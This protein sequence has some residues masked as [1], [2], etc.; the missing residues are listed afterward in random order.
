M[1]ETPERR[2]VAPF[3]LT[4]MPSS[5]ELA[6]SHRDLH[7]AALHIVFPPKLPQAADEADRE[8]EVDS[9]IC[10]LAAA[11]ARRYSD[12]LSSEGLPGAEFWIR[13]AMMIET[14]GGLVRLP[15]NALELKKTLHDMKPRGASAS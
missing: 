6:G 2:P 5:T 3:S 14:L 12:R 4:A 10:S 9:A 11:C 7:D 13:M 15:L 8:R 1:W